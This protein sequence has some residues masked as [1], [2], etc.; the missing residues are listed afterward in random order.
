M[1]P[2]LGV[3][4]GALW[5][6]LWLATGGQSARPVPWHCSTTP[7]EPCF[8]HHG[9]LSSQNG[10]ALKIWLIGTNRMV[11]LDND[12]DQLPPVV[13]KYLDM[14]SPNHS[15]IYGDFDICPTEPDIPGHLRRACV[16][17][18]ERLVVQ[19]VRGLRRPFRIL[20]TWPSVGRSPATGVI[21]QRP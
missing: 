2:R 7:I 14:T 16:A 9:R 8:S 1:Q 10:I 20:S 13:V 11:G 4:L 3:E 6:G 17:G 15:Y 19:D 18:A 5:L 12:G 21:R